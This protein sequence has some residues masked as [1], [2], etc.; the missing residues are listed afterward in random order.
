MYTDKN[1][2]IKPF[3]HRETEHIIKTSI[4][5]EKIGIGKRNAMIMKHRSQP[6]GKTTSFAIT[7]C[8]LE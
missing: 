8:G 6:E 3:T 5:L 7:S 4:K 2:E 1:G